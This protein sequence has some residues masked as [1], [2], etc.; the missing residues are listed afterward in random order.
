M[1]GAVQICW[2]LRRL[3]THWTQTSDNKPLKRFMIT[4]S[5]VQASMPTSENNNVAKRSVQTTGKG[6]TCFT[7]CW[8]GTLIAERW[9]R[10]GTTSTIAKWQCQ[11]VHQDKSVL[12]QLVKD[13][14]ATSETF[15]HYYTKLPTMIATN[16]LS[17]SIGN[18]ACDKQRMRLAP[19]GQS[20]FSLI[21]KRS[22][23]SQWTSL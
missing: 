7:S 12:F 9:V 19:M 21:L 2:S 5:M 3:D 15:A 8:L 1:E 14:L 16:A 17:T 11:I 13:A 23:V 20:C 22:R 4:S 18:L 10:W 6:Q